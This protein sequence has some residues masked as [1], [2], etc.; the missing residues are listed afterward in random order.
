MDN[1][2]STRTNDP[3]SLAKILG[4]WLAV[5]E[6]IGILAWIIFPALGNSFGVTYCYPKGEASSGSRAG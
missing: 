2:S 5:S 4:L 6:P 1:S 3:Y